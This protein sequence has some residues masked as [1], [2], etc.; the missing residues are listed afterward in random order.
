[1]KRKCLKFNTDDFI[2]SFPEFENTN[3][4]LYLDTENAI[5]ILDYLETRKKKF[6]MI[7]Y[8]IFSQKNDEDFYGKEDV[9]EKA[10]F[11]TAM[12]FSSSENVRIY[13]KE[14]FIGGKKIVMIQKKLKKT[15]K[16]NKALKI[17]L[18]T[19]GGYE[20]EFS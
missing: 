7:L 2:K 9:S 4:E 10:K 15:N 16:V 8:H 3:I 14:F 19:L 13:C 20:Y 5:E 1:M 11:I 6:K 12:K 17:H 18:E